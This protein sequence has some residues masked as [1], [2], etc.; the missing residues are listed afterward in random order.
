M[1]N[2]KNLGHLSSER[3][4]CIPFMTFAANPGLPQDETGPCLRCLWGI[5]LC[6]FASLKPC[7]F[8]IVTSSSSLPGIVTNHLHPLFHFLQVKLSLWSVGHPEVRGRTW[9]AWGSRSFLCLA[10]TLFS[11]VQ[12]ILV[13]ST[14]AFPSV[15]KVD[16]NISLTGVYLCSITVIACKQL[17]IL[18]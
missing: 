13:L 5:R 11:L 18:G 1:Q 17:S 8:C 9:G 6:H 7:P 4:H 16:N 10:D 3:R 12:V 14:S 2:W 15:K